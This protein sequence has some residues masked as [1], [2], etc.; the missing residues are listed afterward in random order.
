MSWILIIFVH[1]GA[2][3]NADSMAMTSVSGFQNQ[4]ACQVAGES[5]TKMATATTKSM[6]FVCV[7]AD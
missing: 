2:L 4:R 5:A 7:K 1:A 3:S 6:K